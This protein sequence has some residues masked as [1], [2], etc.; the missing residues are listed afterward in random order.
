MELANDGTSASIAI[1]GDFTA[2]E[3][4]ALIVKLAMLRSKM[5][6]PVAKRPPNGS[7]PPERTGLFADDAEMTV[8]RLVDGRFRFWM[9]NIGLGWC[10][11]NVPAVTAQGVCTF[12]ST[13][14]SATGPA[15]DLFSDEV[16]DKPH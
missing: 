1:T 10:A 11:Y 6:P 5:T 15:V 3:V 13:R 14:L 4:E 16:S 8:A 12:L 9:R 2:L 7:E